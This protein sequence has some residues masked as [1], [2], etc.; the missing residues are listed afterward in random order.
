MLSFHAHLKV[1]VATSPCDLRASFW[2]QLSPGQRAARHWDREKIS[3]FYGLGD[4]F[5]ACFLPVRSL[6]LL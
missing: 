2:N 5:W 6:W 4:V 3:S 1:F